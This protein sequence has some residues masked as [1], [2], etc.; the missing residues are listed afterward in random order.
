MYQR[1]SYEIGERELRFD[2][3]CR[4]PLVWS[5]I[6]I[7]GDGRRGCAYRYFVD[8]RNVGGT[9]QSELLA[10]SDGGIEHGMLGAAA[11]IWLKAQLVATDS[12]PNPSSSF[13]ASWPFG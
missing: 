6:E 9:F 8:L 2:N 7:V 4:L 13:A 10:R 12:R 1:R 5:A 3:L 11:R